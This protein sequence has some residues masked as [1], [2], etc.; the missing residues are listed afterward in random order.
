MIRHLNGLGIACRRL[1]EIPGASTAAAPA[2]AAA[3]AGKAAKVVKKPVAKETPAKNLTVAVAPKP[4]AATPASARGTTTRV[5]VAEVVGLL[6]K[7]TKPAKLPSLKS[8]IKSWFKPALQ[9]KAVDAIVLSLQGGNQIT[10][11]GSKVTYLLG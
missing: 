1:P 3:P 6:K 10:V 2:S 5:R 11:S 7:S 4:V 8:A 9:D